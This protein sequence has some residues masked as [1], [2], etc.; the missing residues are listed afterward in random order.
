MRD[1]IKY[2]VLR[3]AYC[4]VRSAYYLWVVGLGLIIAGCEP[5]GPPPVEIIVPTAVRHTPTPVEPTPTETAVPTEPPSP[6]PG[7]T[8]PAPT[9]PE[10]ANPVVITR[11][12]WNTLRLTPGGRVV[13]PTAGQDVVLWVGPAGSGLGLYLYNLRAGKTQLLAKPS[14]PGGCVCRGYQRGD[15]V[16]MVEAES[17][18]PWWEV[19]ALNL[20]TNERTLIGRTDDPATL[21][22]IRPSEI[23]INAD[24]VVVWK[25]VHTN[26]DGSVQESLYLQD[27]VLG[28]TLEIVSVRSPARIGQVGMYGNWVIWN[29]MAEGE[30]GARGDVFAYDLT[31]DEMYPVGETGR[32]WMPAIWETT[33][34]WKDADDPFAD[35]DVFLFDLETGEGRSLTTDGQAFEVGAGDGFAVWSSVPAGVV[36]FHDLETGAEEVFGRGLIGHLAAADNTIVWLLDDDPGTLYLAWR[37]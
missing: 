37:Q 30:A 27:A 35:G 15:W 20:A 7:P 28:D 9:I 14:T 10:P 26:T 1:W 11:E 31:A 22:A 25:D 33:V 4:V 34:V 24:G 32:A 3:S 6:S 18:A 21:T 19:S 36:V 17:G 16:V 29:L 2:C 23:A 12:G 13:T 5:T 8:E